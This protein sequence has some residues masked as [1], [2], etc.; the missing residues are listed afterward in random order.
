MHFCK[1]SHYH[2]AL[3]SWQIYTEVL[4]DV[5][6]NDAETCKINFTISMNPP[7]PWSL[8]ADDNSKP[9]IFNISLLTSVPTI[10]DTWNNKPKVGDWVA[11]V[12]V[13]NSG[14]VKV[15]GGDCACRKGDTAQFL[16]Y[17]GS[18]DK[19][20]FSWY[21]KLKPSFLVLWI[22]SDLIL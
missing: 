1:L 9:Q 2:L 21:G 19:L 6:S 22:P 18:S 8:E 7:A 11:T 16:I 13:S 20:H 15:Y 5:P 4:F 17:P 14:E 10:N 12:Q 3:T